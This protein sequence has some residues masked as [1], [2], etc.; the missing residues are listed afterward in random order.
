MSV[1]QGNYRAEAQPYR[2]RGIVYRKKSNP[3]HLIRNH[4]ERGQVLY[5]VLLVLLLLLGWIRIVKPND[6]LALVPI[7]S[8]TVV[9]QIGRLNIHRSTHSIRQSALHRFRQI[10]VALWAAQDIL[11][12]RHSCLP[13]RIVLV[14]K[15]SLNVSC[16]AIQQRERGRGANK[17]AFQLAK[18]IRAEN[19]NM[20]QID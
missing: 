10:T 17:S 9:I 3:A 20:T 15:H 13:L 14:Q 1:T 18:A 19:T 12:S 5:D 2:R 6:Q 16:Q 7:S 11:F 4:P 8:E